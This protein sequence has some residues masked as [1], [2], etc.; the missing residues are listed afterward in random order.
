MISSVIVASDSRGIVLRALCLP[1]P[2]W[3]TDDKEVVEDVLTI[4]ATEF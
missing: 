2:T 3:W 1:S 4:I